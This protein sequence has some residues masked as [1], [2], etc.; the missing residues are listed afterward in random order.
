M[1]KLNK[2]QQTARERQISEYLISQYGEDY[3]TLDDW[4]C[5]CYCDDG[6]VWI[7]RVEFKTPYK[8]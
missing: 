4:L 3:F 1:R 6:S 2:T 7:G 8:L 5:M